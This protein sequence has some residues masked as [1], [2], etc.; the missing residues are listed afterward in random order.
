MAL[1]GLMMTGTQSFPLRCQVLSNNIRSAGTL[2][3][4]LRGHG[5]DALLQ[6]LVNELSSHRPRGFS[7]LRKQPPEALRDPSWSPPP[8]GPKSEGRIASLVHPP[9]R[10]P[11]QFEK[12]K[13]AR[14][15]SPWDGAQSGSWELPLNGKI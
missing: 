1:I 2:G 10:G 14:P 4:V 9:G 12:V 5:D 11:G 6:L 7:G 3:C 13:A 15:L 8:P